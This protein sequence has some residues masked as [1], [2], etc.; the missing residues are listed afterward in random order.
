MKPRSSPRLDA[1]RYLVF[2]FVFCAVLAFVDLNLEAV[3]TDFGLVACGLFTL[4]GYLLGDVIFREIYGWWPGQY[5]RED[6][7]VSPGASLSDPFADEG[8]DGRSGLPR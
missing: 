6:L 1:S 2:L 7:T 8:V 5:R 4:F 3:L